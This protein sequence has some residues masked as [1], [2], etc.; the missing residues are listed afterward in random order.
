MKLNKSVLALGVT[1]LASIAN[2]DES[3][4][5][6]FWHSL[7]NGAIDAVCES[8]NEQSKNSIDCI[9]QGDY[10]TAMQKAVAAIRSNNHPVLMQFFDVGTTDL[11]M[12]GISKPL[13]ESYRDV[14]WSDYISGAR[15]YYQ[16]A[17]N[18]LMSQ[19]WNASTVVLYVNKGALA[20]VGITETPS[21]YE[22]LH[23][24]MVKLKES[25]H[26]CPYTTD[27][28]AWRILEQVAA[29]H[30]V[31]IATKHNGFDGLDAEYTVN[32]GL[33]VQ[34]LNNLYDWNQKGL[35]KLDPQTRA[36]RYT[37]AFTANECAMME[38]SLSAYNAS[39][40]ALGSD[41]EIS[42]AP[43]YEGYD[44]YNTFVGGGSL[45]ML[46]GHKTKEETVAKEF[47]D[48][49][50]KPQTQKTLTE[51][52]G[53]LPV[54]QDAY[55]YII[56]T[57]DENDPKFASIHA[58]FE[59]LNQPSN[60]NSRGIRL[61]FYTQFRSVFQE[62]T[63]KAFSGDISMQTALDNAKRRGDQLL[64]RFERTYRHNS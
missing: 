29:R 6:E 18:K 1:G 56:D 43:V 15:G 28:G 47:L 63:Q 17:D 9:Y 22:E 41:L 55:Q 46:D 54:T 10:D 30:G 23:T 13:E 16:D 21:T 42:M 60:A 59:S 44:R 11:M 36:G 3:A 39:S 5:I 20:E 50:R 64:R 52:T 25:G 12:S 32:Q 49:V 40:S 53:Y 24:A 33:I 8:F 58:G 61:G 38:A 26:E 19:P 48:Y 31:D 4:S 45:W 34:H 57:T 2:A 62:E 14:N 27:G 7:N 37:S 35:V 51:M